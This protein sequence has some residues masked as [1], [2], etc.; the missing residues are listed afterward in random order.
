VNGTA[1]NGVRV[2]LDSV[3]F[4]KQ[5]NPGLDETRLGSTV[6]PIF[7]VASRAEVDGVYARVI[8]AGHPSH[9][10]P[11]DAF[12]GARY[13]IVADPDGC[14]VGIMSPIDDSRRRPPPPLPGA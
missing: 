1:A 5:W 10:A 12:W 3:W 13:A 11:E 7:H 2:E 4:A 14:S 8:A 6:I 9:K